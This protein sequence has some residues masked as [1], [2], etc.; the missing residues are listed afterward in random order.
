MLFDTAAFVEMMRSRASGGLPVRWTDLRTD[1]PIINLDDIVVQ[2]EAHIDRLRARH[3]DAKELRAAERTL[4]VVADPA[5]IHFPT[6]HTLRFAG[7]SSQ[8]VESWLV[9]GVVLAVRTGTGERFHVSGVHPTAC[10]DSTA[11]VHPTARVDAWA[12]IGPDVQ[13]GPHA[14]VGADTGVGIHTRIG[15]GVFLGNRVTVGAS[16][17]IGTGARVDADAMLGAGCRVDPAANV[18]ARH[19]VAARGVV[20]HVLPGN[21]ADPASVRV[22]EIP[23]AIERQFDPDNG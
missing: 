16:C 17:R 20:H 2:V 14:H 12:A 8:Y 6:G 15:G 9:S 1:A 23:A 18:P 7:G 13:V 10:V 4:L 21:G 19:R 22:S 5:C 11:T 3:A